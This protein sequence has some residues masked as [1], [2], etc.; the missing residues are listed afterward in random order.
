MHPS[1]KIVKKYGMMQESG[2]GQH[3][4]NIVQVKADPPRQCWVLQGAGP[5]GKRAM[6]RRSYP[7]TNYIESATV[8]SRKLFG[9]HVDC[10]TYVIFR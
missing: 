10:R 8:A 7:S 9:F 4:C 5:Q 6:S 1:I 3:W 2:P